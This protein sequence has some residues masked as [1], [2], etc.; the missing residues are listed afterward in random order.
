MK[1]RR[2]VFVA[3]VHG[4][5]KGYFCDR[6]S[7]LIDGEHVTASSLI[8]GRKELGESKAISGIDANQAMLIEELGKLD[9]SKP[10]VLLD[11]HF[12]LYNKLYEIQP[13]NRFLFKE[14][15]VAYIV[16]LICDPSVI[17]NRLVQRDNNV[18]NLSMHH[19]EKLQNAEVEHARLVSGMLN[20]P[21]TFLDVSGDGISSLSELSEE[22]VSHFSCK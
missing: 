22:I 16:M 4:V 11:G 7:L 21:L 5:G 10:F 8:K 15:N 3:G 1:I 6:L 13:I 9:V 19:L 14:L 12:C 17:L 2:V 18:S 20:V